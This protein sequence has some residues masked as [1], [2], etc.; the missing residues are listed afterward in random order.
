MCCVPFSKRHPFQSAQRFGLYGQSKRFERIAF[1]TF[2]SMPPIASMSSSNPSK[3][4][5]TTWSMGRPVS[6]F[7]VA[8][9]SAGP[10]IWFAALIFDDP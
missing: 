1:G 10:P 5:T 6:A 4:T 3:S 2:T 7:T 8:S 9:V